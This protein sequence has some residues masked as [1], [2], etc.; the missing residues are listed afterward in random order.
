M[1]QDF[2]WCSGYQVEEDLLCLWGWHYDNATPFSRDTLNGGKLIWYEHMSTLTQ[3][4]SVR[5]LHPVTLIKQLLTT[6]GLFQ[7]SVPPLSPPHNFWDSW[8]RVSALELGCYQL[9]TLD[10][11][12]SKVSS[13]VSF[14]PCLSVL[15][16][17]VNIALLCFPLHLCYPCPHT[18]CTSN[19]PINAIVTSECTALLSQK[20]GIRGV[21]N[22]GFS[23]CAVPTYYCRSKYS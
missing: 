19:I 2:T 13:L 4:L 9:L 18:S 10:T 20:S 1:R 11:I 17:H 8:N 23:S 14:W 3:W 21:S 5:V 16:I 22:S 12:Y 15:I 6:S 7:I